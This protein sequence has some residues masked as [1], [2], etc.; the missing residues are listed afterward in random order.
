MR[1]FFLAEMAVRCGGRGARLMLRGETTLRLWLPPLLLLAMMTV[2]AP[3]A[4]AGCGDDA[5]TSDDDDATSSDDDSDDNDVTSSDD[6]DDDDEVTE[7]P[8]NPPTTVGG[9]RP[10][11]VIRPKDYDPTKSYPLLMVLHGFGAT[12][13]A[14]D[15]YF[16]LSGR[17][18]RDQFVLIRPDG[19][20]N[21][22]KQRFW[23]ATPACCAF[24]QPVDDVAYLTG[25]VEE[26]K[27][28]H[29][30][31]AGRVYLI[32]HSNGGFMSYR[33][34]CEASEVFTGIVS[35]AGATYA[36]MTLCAPATQPVS[37]LQVHGTADDTI[38]YDGG[39]LGVAG[40]GDYPSAEGS[41]RQHAAIAGCDV[42]AAVDG[43]TRDI[44]AQIA[45]DETTT[46]VWGTGCAPGTAFELW[47]IPGGVHI[48]PI[49]RTAG[50]EMIAWL[51]ALD[52]TP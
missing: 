12:G 11:T 13:L 23:N 24:G 43:A 16:G 48:P 1:F 42:D 37:V 9:E 15:V 30:I 29:N 27:A 38:L 28:S 17:V 44:D 52:R 33:L 31:D 21:G 2:A 39:N 46:R 4:L 6:D 50:R 3:V 25:L 32:G 51:F 45:G 7:Y 18:D 5:A 49:T 26:V 19:T 14:Q 22:K 8:E 20:M 10:A 41:V 47:T 36:D 35:L 40:V 34:A